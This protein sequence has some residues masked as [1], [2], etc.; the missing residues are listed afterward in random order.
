L[1]LLQICF[2]IGLCNV[3]RHATPRHATPRH[4]TPRHAT[5]TSDVAR[6][7]KNLLIACHFPAFLILVIFGTVSASRADGNPQNPTNWTLM[8]IIND[9]L[10]RYSRHE[11]VT[12]Y[13]VPVLEFAQYES[14][15]DGSSKT[16]NGFPYEGSLTGPFLKTIVEAD[17]L[18]CSS[19]GTQKLRFQ[20]NQGP[21]YPAPSS[22]RVRVNSGASSFVT[23]GGFCTADNGLNGEL[24]YFTEN[25]IGHCSSVT[26]EIRELKVEGGIATIELTKTSGA[27]K[28]FQY[29]ETGCVGANSINASITVDSRNVRIIPSG[30]AY[31]SELAGDL[32]NATF[33]YYEHPAR[34]EAPSVSAPFFYNR[35]NRKPAEI[36]YDSPAA[37]YA[38]YKVSPPTIKQSRLSHNQYPYFEPSVVPPHTFT[39][40][41]LATSEYQAGELYSWNLGGSG[42][43]PNAQN[44]FTIPD[45]QKAT[46][47]NVA[48]Q[49]WNVEWYPNINWVEW[50][51]I[52]YESMT[53]T[54]TYTWTDGVIGL[55]TRTVEFVEPAV[56]VTTASVTSYPPVY[57]QLNFVNYGNEVP[58]GPDSA[59]AIFTLKPFEASLNAV[60]SGTIGQL[61]E[62]SNPGIAAAYKAATITYDEFVVN[63][64]EPWD[65]QPINKLTTLN[66]S[67]WEN[68]GLSPET[69]PPGWPNTINQFSWKIKLRKAEIFKKDVVDVYDTAGFNRR[70]VRFDHAA[71][72]K[73]AWNRVYTYRWQP[74]GGGSE[75][76]G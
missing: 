31:V 6:I 37:N 10:D 71:F 57:E 61:V 2:K 7:V 68:T 63:E 56:L 40:Y 50:L 48:R 15:W 36:R 53:L 16:R 20:W 29:N 19:V 11:W 46:T 4:A 49:E 60:I 74:P 62:E 44:S 54:L 69:P 5:P 35:M 64:P 39:F 65:P 59:D 73:E 52:P 76:P 24:E 14:E 17:T 22:V 43:L 27:S 34:Y 45:F 8:P 21:I 25:G 72:V 38:E 18:I 12:P 67:L 23:V 55:S 33:A 30:G 28:S 32:V 58:V 9:G 47:L 13:G 3:I 26:S 51:P 75:Q 1:T 41:G 42:M 70:D 66:M